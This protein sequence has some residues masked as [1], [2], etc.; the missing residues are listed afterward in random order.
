MLPP[1]CDDIITARFR[2][3]EHIIS[4]GLANFK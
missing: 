2:S 3:A 1:K 4:Y